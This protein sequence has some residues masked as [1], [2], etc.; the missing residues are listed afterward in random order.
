MVMR[1][2]PLS[3]SPSIEPRVYAT[4]FQ[5]EKR[6]KGKHQKLK[7]AVYYSIVSDDAI[8]TAFPPAL[9]G[10]DCR[11]IWIRKFVISISLCI[12]CHSRKLVSLR[13]F[14]F[15]YFNFCILLLLLCGI[16]YR[17]R[18]FDVL[19]QGERHQRPERASWKADL[20]RGKS[21]SIEHHL[22]AIQRALAV[23]NLGLHTKLPLALY[24]V[25]M[26]VAAAYISRRNI[27][28]TLLQNVCAPQS[29]EGRSRAPF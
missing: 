28:T 17:L 7:I 15:S 1:V 13:L 4:S 11:R 19:H 23:I 21:L 9:Y 12:I 25:C 8:T 24:C 26:A 16:C 2:N 29:N 18:I 6:E 27:C 14:I 5:K 22:S 3:L 10:L 20:A